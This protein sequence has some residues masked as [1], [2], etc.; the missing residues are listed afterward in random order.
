MLREEDWGRYESLI[1]YVC[2]EALRKRGEELSYSEGKKD[3]FKQDLKEVML[4]ICKA[5]WFG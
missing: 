4:S 2:S 3:I 5:K 1:D